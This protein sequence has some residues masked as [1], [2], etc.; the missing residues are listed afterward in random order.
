LSTSNIH[1]LTD[2]SVVIERGADITSK[3]LQQEIKQ[4]KQS[5][6]ISASQFPLKPKDILECGEAEDTLFTSKVRFY[7][8]EDTKQ[9]RMR[10]LL[11][12][13]KVHKGSKEYEIF[14]GQHVNL[15]QYVRSHLSTLDESDEERPPDAGLG[16][17]LE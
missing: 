9:F 3:I 12:N 14:E 2:E 11:V 7:R 5:D 16:P 10:N 17:L 8:D 6:L 15:T 13:L 1:A 4:E